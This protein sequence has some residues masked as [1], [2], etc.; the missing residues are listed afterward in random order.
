VIKSFVTR[1][2]WPQT[3]YNAFDSRLSWRLAIKVLETQ[4]I[5]CQLSV[6][7]M[8]IQKPTKSKH[9]FEILWP[10]L[11]SCSARQASSSDPR[12]FILKGTVATHSLDASVVISERTVLSHLLNVPINIMYE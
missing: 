2:S 8:A 3:N 7:V 4:L 9:T 11:H 1:L 10:R 5:F 12:L 6:A